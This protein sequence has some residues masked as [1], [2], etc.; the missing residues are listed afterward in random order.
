M[1]EALAPL[2]QWSEEALGG[3]ILV[4]A[5]VAAAV[6]LMP[7]FGSSLLPMRVRLGVAVAFTLVVW[8]MVPEARGVALLPA[9]G[10]EIAAGV[11]IGLSVRLLVM[12]LQFAGAIAAQ[13]T[14]LAQLLGPGAM[15][16]P[17]PAMGALLTLAGVTLAMV[18]GLHIRIAEALVLSYELIPAGR[19]PDAGDLA[20]WSVART[21]H[22]VTLGITLAAPFLLVALAYNVAL[23]AIN[24]A[25][26]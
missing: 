18:L 22:A 5:R 23:G 24:R 3:L 9:L 19:L 4:F 16:D 2:V 25:M 12:A 8:P 6:G 10:V 7:G 14:S 17:M 21:A 13:S 11:I 26:P 1:I 20:Q 15:P